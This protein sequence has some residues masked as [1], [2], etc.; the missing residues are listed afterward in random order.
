[1]QDIL[2]KVRDVREKIRNAAVKAGRDVSEIQIIAVTKTIPVERIKEAVSA[3]L[4]VLGENRVQELV[5]KFPL[6]EG[7]NWHLIGHLQSNKVKYITDKVKL[8]HSLD[9]IA[10]AEVMNKKMQL[11][12]S[13]L[14]VLIQVNVAEEESKFGIKPDDVVSFVQKVSIMPYLKIKGLMTVAPKAVNPEEVRP[15]FRKL[16]GLFD[17]IK[18][19]E[20]PGIDMQHLSMGMSNDYSVAIEEGATM[21][22]LGSA[23]F[24]P[25]NYT[26]QIIN[27]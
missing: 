8:V 6:I 9:S 17:D 10:L 7:V 26:D 16:R 27:N 12:N 5:N 25:R 19:M 4:T 3:G 11:R 23:I 21:I 2:L 13:I 20:I 24:G 22:R 1:M 15:V 18:K 14:D